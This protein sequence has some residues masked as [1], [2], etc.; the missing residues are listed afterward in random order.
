MTMYDRITG[1]KGFVHRQELYITIKH[2]FSE[3]GSVS[4]FSG[5]EGEIYSFGSLRKC[6]YD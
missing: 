6:N 2:N 4:V 1:F 3:T 5:G